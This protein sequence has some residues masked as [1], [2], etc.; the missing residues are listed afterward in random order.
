M[1]VIRREGSLSE[2]A[3][4]GDTAALPHNE[5]AHPP[6]VPTFIRSSELMRD[7]GSASGSGRWMQN[8]PQVT[9]ELARHGDDGLGWSDAAPGH[10]TEAR[11]Q[12]LLT[13]IG[14]GQDAGGLS[15]ASSA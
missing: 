15:L 4:W 3:G 5:L 6:I 1:T 12:A 7:G 9:G 8:R 11:A 2:I 14:N 10:A 13:T